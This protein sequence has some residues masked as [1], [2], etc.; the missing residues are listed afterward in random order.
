[1]GRNAGIF[2][3]FGSNFRVSAPLSYTPGY[4]R[5]DGVQIN[6]RVKI[7]CA[8][9]GLKNQKT[10][11]A[12]TDFFQFVAWGK[13]ADFCAKT[14]NKGR[15]FDATVVPHTFQSRYF[16]NNVPLVGANGQPILIDRVAFTITQFRIGEEAQELVDE[17]IRAG[18]RPQYWNVK[19]HPDNN[20]WAQIIATR[21]SAT[22]IPGSQKFGYANVVLPNVQAGVAN[23]PGM[24]TLP[25]MASLPNMVQQAFTPPQAPMAPAPLNMAGD[26]FGNGG[27]VPKQPVANNAGVSNVPVF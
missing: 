1:M 21:K 4:V 19:N 10:G 2:M 15:A 6:Q 13:L 20:I 23:I 3:G 16:Q 17:E 5:A 24:N 18:R 25:N 12:G 7:P 14:L 26:I 11:V 27:F 22:Y 9:N 8:I